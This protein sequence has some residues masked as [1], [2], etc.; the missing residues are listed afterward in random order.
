[1]SWLY[2]I[3]IFGVIVASI[4][5]ARKFAKAVKEL[6]SGYSF[7]FFLLDDL[8]GC[9]KGFLWPILLPISLLQM[10][11]LKGTIED[12]NKEADKRLKEYLGV[13]DE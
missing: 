4:V 7:M 11:F 1:M 10:F 6:K 9:S 5:E 3:Y 13:D 12:F 2:S 8:K